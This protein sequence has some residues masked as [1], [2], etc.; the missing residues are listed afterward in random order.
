MGL[1]FNYG[2]LKMAGLYNVKYW[3]RVKLKSLWSYSVCTS[4]CFPQSSGIFLSSLCMIARITCIHFTSSS[5]WSGWL[6]CCSLSLNAEMLREWTENM[7]IYHW[8]GIKIDECYIHVIHVSTPRAICTLLAYWRL[9]L[10]CIYTVL[11][12]TT[13]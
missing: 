4:V 9:N 3:P 13:Y 12:D 8:V 7:V 10:I 1:E 11:R 6:L 2:Y 5:T